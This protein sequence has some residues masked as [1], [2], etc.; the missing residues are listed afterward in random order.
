MAAIANGI[1]L[2]GT[3]LPYCGTF[4]IF[5]DYMRPAIRLAALMKT[6]TLFVFTHDSI[7]VGEDGPTHQ[8][9]EQLDSLRIVPGLTV[10]RPADGVETAMA[11]AYHLQE[12]IGPVLLSLTRQTVPALERPAT[13]D[14]LD[15]WKGAYIVS[16]PD[17]KANVVLVATGSEVGVAVE[18]AQEL[19]TGGIRARVVSMPCVGLFLE[20]SEADQDAIIPDDGTPIVAIEAGR[21]ETLRRFVGR[22]G[23]VIGMESFG[24]SAPYADLA[25]HFGFTASSVATRIK[26]HV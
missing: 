10:F 14:P 15:V 8:P 22:R 4:M 23:L 25:I 19:A 12:S 18:A 16:E 26:A 9:V 17:E 6:R 1:S 21:G 7:F 3:F 2:D 13:F 5:S 11:Y 24:A 20:Q